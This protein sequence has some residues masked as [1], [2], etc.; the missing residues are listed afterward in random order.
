MVLP[1]WKTMLFFAIMG[2]VT[3]VTK[4]MGIEVP[5]DVAA[6]LTE[7]QISKLSGHGQEIYLW[8]TIVGGF[9]FRSI[10]NSPVF[11]KPE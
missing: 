9:F 4:Y 8:I 6:L 3:V 2:A 1:G 11:K 7:E 10:T 5:P